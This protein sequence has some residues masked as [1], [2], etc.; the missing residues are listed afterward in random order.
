[1]SYPAILA[2]TGQGYTLS[3]V[4]L[5]MVVEGK[6]EQEAVGIAADVLSR[7]PKELRPPEAWYAEEP[8]EDRVVWIEA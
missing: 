5:S 3:I 6:T 8:D 4:G 1:M 2:Q 7:L